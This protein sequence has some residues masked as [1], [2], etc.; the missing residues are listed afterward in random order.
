LGGLGGSFVGQG[1][2][3]IPEIN[4]EQNHYLKVFGFYFLQAATNAT[5][6]P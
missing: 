5:L 6:M 2:Y 3:L 1:I 4:Q